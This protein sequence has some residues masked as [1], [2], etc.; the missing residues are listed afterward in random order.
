LSGGTIGR[1]GVKGTLRR[2]PAPLAPA[3]QSKAAKRSTESRGVPKKDGGPEIHGRVVENL[4]AAQVSHATCPDMPLRGV[5]GP[6][7]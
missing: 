5:D 3:H 4:M 7:A 2:P 6:T 1:A